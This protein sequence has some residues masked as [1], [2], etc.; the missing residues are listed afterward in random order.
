MSCCASHE[1]LSRSQPLLLTFS[2]DSLI[3]LHG[4]FDQL[5]LLNPAPL[6]SPQGADKH[7]KTPD[8]KCPIE[9]TENDAIKALF[10]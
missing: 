7:Q 5:S 9:C 10:K 8:G 2:P 6:L 1:L 4:R 3:K